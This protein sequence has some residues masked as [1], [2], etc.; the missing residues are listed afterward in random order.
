M[1]PEQIL[2]AI[3]SRTSRHPELRRPLGWNGFKRICERERIQVFRRP[4]PREAQLVPFLGAWA[5][6]LNSELHPRRNTYFGAHELG[7]LWLHHDR[8]CERWERCFNLD[9]E[10]R[11]DPREDDAELFAM[12]VM[13]GPSFGSAFTD[14]H[15]PLRERLERVPSRPIRMIPVEAFVAALRP[16][17]AGQVRGL[18]EAD[19][20]ATQRLCNQCAYD[21]GLTVTAERAGEML[22]HWNCR[23]DRGCRCRWAAMED[24]CK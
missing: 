8:T 12:M 3:H 5:I 17:P 18:I 2:A 13:Q 1:T 20:F 23:C 21:D 4:L 22:P 9:V 16:D 11:D 24:A 14:P 10:W 6:L 15:A 7:H 19:W